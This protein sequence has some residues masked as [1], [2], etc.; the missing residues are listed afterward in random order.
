ML[1][2]RQDSTVSAKH[3]PRLCRVT[4]VSRGYVSVPLSLFSSL[5]VLLKQLTRTGSQRGYHRDAHWIVGLTFGCHVRMGFQRYDTSE[6]FT[7]TIPSGDAVI[8]NGALH[9]HAVLGIDEGTAPA[10]WRYP[11]SRVVF[12]MRDS[13][14]SLAAR[15]RR[16]ER[17]AA[18]L[19]GGKEAAAK[20]AMR[21]AAVAK[22]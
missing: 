19:R 8:F 22:T 16:D 3:S 5:C 7:L 6:K 18:A 2:R 11:F 1:V 17:R 13:R 15:R 20:A 12:L 14:Q 4:C 9:S 10:W 21:L